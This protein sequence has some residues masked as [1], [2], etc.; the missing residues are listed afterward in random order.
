MSTTTTTPSTGGGPVVIAAATILDGLV[1]RW[2]GSTAVAE[3]GGPM[4]SASRRGVRIHGVYLH[5]V[6]AGWLEDA[7]R[8]YELLCAGHDHAAERELVTHRLTDGWAEA[9]ERPAKTEQ[10]LRLMEPESTPGG[11]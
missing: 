11:A 7:E 1:L 2:Y 10:P 8:A 5:E 4:L 6:P 9:I 3:Y